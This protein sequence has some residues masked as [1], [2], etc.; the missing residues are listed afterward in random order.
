MSDGKHTRWI[1]WATDSVGLY[2]YE[3]QAETMKAF[4]DERGHGPCLIQRVDRPTGLEGKAYFNRCD[5]CG[6]DNSA[7][8]ADGNCEECR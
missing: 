2:E 3:Q 7:P 5:S 4:L 1:V 6:Y 8:D